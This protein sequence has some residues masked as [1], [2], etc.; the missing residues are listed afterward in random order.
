MTLTKTGK[1]V[2]CKCKV[3]QKRTF[4]PQLRLGEPVPTGIPKEMAERIIAW[5]DKPI[6]CDTDAVLYEVRKVAA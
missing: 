1:C 5:R 2:V 3:K 6:L 4:E